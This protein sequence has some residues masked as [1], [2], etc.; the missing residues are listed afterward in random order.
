MN[1]KSKTS[2]VLGG[3]LFLFFVV[4]TVL[5]TKVDVASIGPE[6]SSV[7][8][9]TINGKVR[10][11]LSLNTKIY[12]I[13]EYLGVVAIATV[14]IFGI[15]GFIQLVKGKSLAAVDKDIIILGI[16]YVVVAA[17]YALFEIVIINYRPVILEEGLEASYPS[18]HSMLA[19]AFLGFTIVQIGK[20][21]SSSGLKTGLQILCVVL[22]I[23]TAGGRLM[24]GVHWVT[25]ICAGT[26]LGLA[27]AFLYNGV[28]QMLE[29]DVEDEDE[30]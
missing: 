1:K 21:M 6:N 7:G 27:Y 16:F 14:P 13:T 18:S 11:M 24:S 2:F 8:F 5:V 9:S 4:F 28:V 10:D 12:D 29:T 3:L 17:T 23:A 15:I 19:L 22:A 26:V 25:D 30:E 20:R